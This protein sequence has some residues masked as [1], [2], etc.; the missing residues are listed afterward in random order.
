MNGYKTIKKFFNSKN[1]NKIFTRAEYFMALKSCKIRDTYMD[2]VRC[3]LVNAGYLKDEEPGVYR[4]LKKI[5][6]DLTLT[7]LQ[8]EAYPYS[9]KSRK[10]QRRT[11]RRHFFEEFP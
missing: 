7:K 8:D 1:C 2:T 4:K 6:D 11:G 3:Y 10:E 5:P 9:I